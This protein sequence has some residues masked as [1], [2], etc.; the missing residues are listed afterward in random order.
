MNMRSDLQIIGNLKLVSATV[1]LRPLPTRIFGRT[2][3][4]CEPGPIGEAA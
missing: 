2:L 1:R 3:V 4:K